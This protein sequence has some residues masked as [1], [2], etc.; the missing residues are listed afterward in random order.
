MKHSLF[1]T[2][3]AAALLGSGVANANE[4]GT[5]Y[6]SQYGTPDHLAESIS[7]GSSRK[8][9]KLVVD[10]PLTLTGNMGYLSLYNGATIEFQKKQEAEAICS[11]STSAARTH[12]TVCFYQTGGVYNIAFNADAQAIVAASAGTPITLIKDLNTG[13][14]GFTF[15]GDISPSD[16]TLQLNGA[17]YNA[18]VVLD[19]VQFT[20]VGPKADDYI[21]QEGEIGFTGYY[22]GSHAL[23]LVAN[24]KPT[25]EPTTGTLSLLALA[26]LCARRRK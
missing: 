22:A 24:G 4:A 20:Y 2:I 3:L 23:K 14:D 26:G 21:F 25:P 9:D 10:V 17:G 16:T 18:P 19:G 6:A 12:Q 5:L 1:L 11:I 8:D 13:N 15:V 7:L